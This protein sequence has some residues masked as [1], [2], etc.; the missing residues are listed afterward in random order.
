M[1]LSSL[2]IT[3]AIDTCGYAPKENFQRIVPYTD[4]FLYDFKFIDDELHNKYTGVGNKQILDNLKYLSKSGARI[5][6]R[7]ILLDG[8]NTDFSLLRSRI[9]WLKDNN[10]QVEEINLLPYHDFGRKKYAQLDRECTQNFSVPSDETLKAIKNIFEESG[11][12]VSIGG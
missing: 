5:F 8:I 2:N 7:M 11:Y 1:F 3:I 12:R 10:I 9:A 6:L 4:I